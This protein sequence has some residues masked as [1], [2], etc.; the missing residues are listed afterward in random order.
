MG[1]KVA[2]EQFGYE[3]SMRAVLEKLGVEIVDIPG[4]GCCGGPMKHLNRKTTLAMSAR[5]LALAAKEGLEILTPCSWC[6]LHLKEADEILS[7]DEKLA[8]EV[9]AVIADEGIRYTPGVKVNNILDVLVDTVGVDTIKSSVTKDMKG[10]KM[11]T[12]Y[13]CH[14]LRPHKTGRMDDPEAPSKMETLLKAVGIESP[15]YAERLNCCGSAV[16]PMEPEMAL[17]KTG[18]KLQ[19]VQE[20]GFQG[21]VNVCAWCQSKMDGQQDAAGKSVGKQIS[22]PSV[23]ITQ[24]LGKAFGIDDEKLGLQL[25]QSPVDKLEGTE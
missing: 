7:G 6:D 4:T 22:V 15:D 20:H 5:N 24:I 13:G 12:H 11:A 14:T 17:T 3:L 16:A 18:Q 9:N 25:N 8:G 21:V 2:T 23:Y 1:C 10:L 19:A